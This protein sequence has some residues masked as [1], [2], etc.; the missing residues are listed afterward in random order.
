[1]YA[2]RP[3]A[4]GRAVADIAGGELLILAPLVVL[5][6]VL[7]AYPYLVVRA[8]AALGQGMPPWS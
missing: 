8:M 6:F 7:G 3:F 5:M 4:E 2:P 1:M